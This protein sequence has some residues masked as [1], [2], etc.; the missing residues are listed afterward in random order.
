MRTMLRR[1]GPRSWIRLAGGAA[2]L[3]VVVVIIL[4]HSSN[5][6]GGR[7]YH[8]PPRSG[9]S[10]APVTARSARSAFHRRVTVSWTCLACQTA[11][12]VVADEPTAAEDGTDMSDNQIGDPTG[13]FIVYAGTYRDVRAS[14]PAGAKWRIDVFDG[15]AE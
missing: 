4:S 9:A 6:T 1:M 7:P 14:A 5:G 12:F 11:Q 8:A 15:P 3:I 10:S 13:Q 2:I